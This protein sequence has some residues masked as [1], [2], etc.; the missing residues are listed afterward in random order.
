V[1]IKGMKIERT[2]EL[3]VELGGGSFWLLLYAHKHQSLS[4]AH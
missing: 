4:Q 3:G 2:G 1:E